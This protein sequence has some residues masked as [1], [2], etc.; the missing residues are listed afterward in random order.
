[1]TNQFYVLT[2]RHIADFNNLEAALAF[3][4]EEADRYDIPKRVFASDGTTLVERVVVFPYVPEEVA[5]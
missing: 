5:L 4:R 3:A 1:M 2:T